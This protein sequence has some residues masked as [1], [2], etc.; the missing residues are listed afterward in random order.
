MT[1]GLSP[2]ALLAFLLPLLAAVGGALSSWIVT[3][4]FN[5]AEIRT[6]AGGLVSSGLA[7]LGAYVGQPGPVASHN[8]VASDDLL[9]DGIK[10][11]LR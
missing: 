3:G 6:A 1:V 7:L 2:K 10:E 8:E 4:D 11:I 5:N 9:G